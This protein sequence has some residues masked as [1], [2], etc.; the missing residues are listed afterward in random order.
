MV[1]WL[2]AERVGARAA[3]WAAATGYTVVIGSTRVYLGVHW[4]TDVLGGWAF[5]AT[6][7][8]LALTIR[9]LISRRSTKAS[10]R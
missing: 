8:A 3:I 2:L 7:L 4:P 5:A 1:A 9:A 10:G 6:W